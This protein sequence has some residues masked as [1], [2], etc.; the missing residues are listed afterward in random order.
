MSTAPA[1]LCPE[2]DYLSPLK[3]NHL[4]GLSD[5]ELANGI[6]QRHQGALEEVYRRHARSVAAAAKMVLGRWPGCE[7]VVA[8]VFLAY[9]L[10]PLSFDLER[11]SLLG[12]LRL[13]ARGRSIDIV[14]S[15]VAR[16]RREET[17]VR[18]NGRLS[19]D[20]DEELLVSEAAEQMHRALSSLIESEREP[21]ELAF[22]AGMTYID[23]AKHLQLPEGT[24]KSRIRAGLQHVRAIFEAQVLAAAES[25]GVPFVQ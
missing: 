1:D 11:G 15:E 20:I 22:F 4:A 9:W 7:D 12:F 3:V 23:V 21:I 6:T 16:R 10:N 2:T 19:H 5:L 24:V 13:K 17:D 14:R 25:E 18:A 8:E